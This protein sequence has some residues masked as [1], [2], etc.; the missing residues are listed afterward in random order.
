VVLNNVMLYHN[1]TRSV[2][3]QRLLRGFVGS[4]LAAIPDRRLVLP[5]GRVSPNCGVLS[6][7]PIT[8]WDVKTGMDA[9]AVVCDDDGLWQWE[10]REEEQVDY[11]DLGRPWYR[12]AVFGREAMTEQVRAHDEIQ[13]L[14]AEPYPAAAPDAA[15]LRARFEAAFARLEAVRARL[16]AEVVAHHRARKDQPDAAYAYSTD[17]PMTVTVFDEP[18]FRERAIKV[19]S[20][21]EPLLYRAAFR[22]SERADRYRDLAADPRESAFWMTEETEAAAEAVVLAVMCL[23]AYVNGAI[24]DAL[25]GLWREMERAELRAKW[26]LL[27]HLLG[28]ADCFDRGT[29]PFQRFNTLVGWRNE[30]AHYKH[31]FADPVPHPD[32]GRVSGLYDMC[33]AGNA[34]VAV[35][36]VA[37]MVRRLCD[38]RGAP[39][40]LWLDNAA[41]WL[42]PVVVP[43]ADPPRAGADLP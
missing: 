43:P 29:Q 41:G 3:T 8:A 7:N 20:H 1:V 25:P 38:R 16:R 4:P 39:V 34:R 12:S 27:P 32:F 31:A 6:W 9:R 22:A 2:V 14:L 13:A 23:E 26:M 36:T 42:N 19:R 40:P 18:A 10:V 15:G 17:P 21:I 11:P 37:A 33:N 5:E 35:E 24:R 28:H 30:L